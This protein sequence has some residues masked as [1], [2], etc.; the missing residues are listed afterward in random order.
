MWMT[1]TKEKVRFRGTSEEDSLSR[2]NGNIRLPRRG[3]LLYSGENGWSQCVIFDNRIAVA[4]I[5][6]FRH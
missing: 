3:Q 1:P 5:L 4:R 6:Q 2:Y